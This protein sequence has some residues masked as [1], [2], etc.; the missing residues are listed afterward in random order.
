MAIITKQVYRP[1][2][3]P[4]ERNL[5]QT[6]E[7][8]YGDRAV[9]NGGLSFRLGRIR[10]EMP[11]VLGAVIDRPVDY[12]LVLSKF[13]QSLGIQ[14]GGIQ[15]VAS[16]VPVFFHKPDE[17]ELIDVPV[18]ANPVIRINYEDYI[19]KHPTLRSPYELTLTVEYVEKC[20]EV[21]ALPDESMR[22][23][24]YDD[25]ALSGYFIMEVDLA[26]YM[27][28]PN[29]SAAL[30]TARRLEAESIIGGHRYMEPEVANTLPK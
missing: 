2:Q 29:Y 25:L 4:Y 13:R 24:I 5:T 18:L 17:M 3:S 8:V 23:R 10:L 22:K 26:K 16:T 20:P 28:D 19:N 14:N 7:P 30:E 12:G 9:T 27:A 15:Q 11:G 21:E 1:F 6:P